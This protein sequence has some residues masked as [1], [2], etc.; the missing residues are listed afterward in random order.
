MGSIYLEPPKPRKTLGKSNTVKE[1]EIPG[2]EYL[3]P[4]KPPAKDLTLV[5]IMQ[6]ALLEKAKTV[7]NLEFKSKK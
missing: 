2:K 7:E 1:P 6:K 3:E 4:A 5:K